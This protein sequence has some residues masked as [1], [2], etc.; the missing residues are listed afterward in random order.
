[1]RRMAMILL[2]LA[3]LGGPGIPASRAQT[4]DYPWCVVYG[5]AQGDGGV[6]C[7]FVSYAQCMLTATPGSGAT[8][9]RNLRMAPERRGTR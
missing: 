1:M 8:C 6:H 4:P 3:G 9:V 7:M 2:A 5:G